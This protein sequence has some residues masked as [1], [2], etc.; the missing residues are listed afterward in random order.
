MN[1]RV[2]TKHPALW[3]ILKWSSIS[4]VAVPALSAAGG[5]KLG[6]VQLTLGMAA[7]A[8]VIGAIAGAALGALRPWM[9]Q[10]PRTF[11][12]GWITV[13]AIVAVVSQL[14]EAMV[15]GE[16]SF[17]GSVFAFIVVLMCGGMDAWLS[18]P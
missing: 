17:Y 16:S 9:K 15:V 3:R 6:S 2:A 11:W 5:A 7:S 1:T 8:G 10:G 13:A 4:A 14:F 18:T 12:A